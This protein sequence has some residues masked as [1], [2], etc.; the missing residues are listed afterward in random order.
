VLWDEYVRL[1]R[2]GLRAEALDKVRSVVASVRVYPALDRGAF[3]DAIVATVASAGSTTMPLRQPLIEGVVLPHLLER[4]DEDERGSARALLAVVDQLDSASCRQ[5]AGERNLSRGAL[6]EHALVQE[7]EAHDLRVR[8]LEHAASSFAYAL[9]ELPAGVLYGM[10]GASI[11]ECEELL[12]ELDG[13]DRRAIAWGLVDRYRAIF[14]DCSNVIG[15]LRT[16]LALVEGP[17]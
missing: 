5:M 4:H 14:A 6:L 11:A 7:P 12:E 16:M 9:H 3:A 13:A 2:L 10:D 17:G 8:W 15:G 1:E